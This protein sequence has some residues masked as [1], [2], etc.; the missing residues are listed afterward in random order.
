MRP[1]KQFFH[2]HVLHRSWRRPSWKIWFVWAKPVAS[3]LLSRWVHDWQL[4]QSQDYFRWME[5]KS[6][7]STV[8]VICRWRTSTSTLRCFPSRTAFWPRRWKPRGRSSKSFSKSRLSSST[9]ASPCDRRGV[10]SIHVSARRPA[11]RWT[12]DRVNLLCE[13]ENCSIKTKIR[14]DC[15]ASLLYFNAFLVSWEHFWK[16]FSPSFAPIFHKLEAAC[17]IPCSVQ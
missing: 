9:A 12:S 8:V 16:Y 6:V 2:A 4:D 5:S 10:V 7:L 17:S 3:T 14:S 1:C 13:A 15:F 11:L